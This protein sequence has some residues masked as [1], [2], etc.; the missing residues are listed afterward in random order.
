MYFVY[1][2]GRYID[3][4]GQ[5]FRDFLAGRLPALP[6]DV[7]T[8]SDWSDHV[9][10]LFPE[11]RLKRFMEMR[12]ADGNPWKGICA[13]P[14]LFVGLL[15]HQ[16]S[17]DAAWDLVKNW[18]PE[19]HAYLRNTVPRQALHAEFQGRSLTELAGAVVEIA[20]AGLKARHRLDSGGND[21]TGFLELLRERVQTGKCPADYLLEDYHERWGESVDQAYV[22]CAY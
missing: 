3:A 10:T 9:S 11:V 12:G 6:G 17:L 19:D 16:S 8:T 20:S 4:S 7:P 18:T 1:R 14:A 22:D 5:S 15:Y 21:E 2:D 13:L